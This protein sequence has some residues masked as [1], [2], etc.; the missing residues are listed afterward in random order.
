MDVT[1]YHNPRCSKSR[2]TLALLSERGIEPHIVEYLRDPP[3]VR[4]LAQLA[5]AL[6]GNARDLLRTGEAEYR[7][8]GL[9]DAAISDDDILE[10]I[11]GH[12]RLL[13]RPVVLC[14]GRARIGRP[15]ENVLE[16]LP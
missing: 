3:D 15:P 10:T 4:T 6:G 13:Q 7:E 8:L 9:D 11:A 1:V 5:D 12:P 2:A 16:I 14:Q